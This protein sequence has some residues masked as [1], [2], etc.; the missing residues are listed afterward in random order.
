M[1]DETLVRDL[2]IMIDRFNELA[3]SSRRVRDFVMDSNTSKFSLR[4]FRSRV[5]DPRVYNLPNADEVAALIVG[6]LDSM[7][8]GRD[9]IV[10]DISGELS[11]IHE[12]H[13]SFI[14]FH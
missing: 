12:T 7:D 11:K 1:Y 2:T 14:P 10:K 5:K 9:I 6:D 4:L 8:V 13:T 3:K